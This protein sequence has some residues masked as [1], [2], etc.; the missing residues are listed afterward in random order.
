MQI[1]RSLVYSIFFI[2]VGASTLICADQKDFENK[3]A[4]Q[5]VGAGVSLSELTLP[6]NMSNGSYAA[7]IE[8]VLKD[9]FKSGSPTPKE[10]VVNFINHILLDDARN[11]SFDLQGIGQKNH[12]EK[13]KSDFME[14]IKRCNIVIDS[15]AGI[16]SIVKDMSHLTLELCNYDL[17]KNLLNACTRLTQYPEFFDTGLKFMQEFSEMGGIFSY[18][19]EFYEFCRKLICNNWDRFCTIEKIQKY[20]LSD[21]QSYKL[22]GALVIGMLIFKEFISNDACS[23]RNGC[24]Y[25]YD[26]ANV[27]RYLRK[28]SEGNACNVILDEFKECY[29][30]IDLLDYVDFLTSEHDN[31]ALYK[32]LFILGMFFSKA[33]AYKNV[34][35]NFL[36][37]ICIYGALSSVGYT[38]QNIVCFL[39]RAR[40]EMPMS[41]EDLVDSC[42]RH[43]CQCPDCFEKMEIDAENIRSLEPECRLLSCTL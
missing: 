43:T 10:A 28:N 20:T 33:Y 21:T 29:G 42:S 7:C 1:I 40:S 30:N 37:S 41:Y 31:G 36:D 27:I 11:G 39:D 9:I 22:I 17:N 23:C 14:F 19:D 12:T 26:L 4:Q 6:I 18:G 16:K 38:N 3:V 34:S 2:C 15:N 32:N 25:L 5:R 8:D 13:D 24:L 35:Y